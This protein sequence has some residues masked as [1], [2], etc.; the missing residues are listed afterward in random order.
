MRARD[1]ARRLRVTRRSCVV[2]LLIVGSVGCGDDGPEQASR[3]EADNAAAS[4][5]GTPDRF[6]KPSYV[7]AGYKVDV[8]EDRGPRRVILTGKSRSGVVPV[9][10]LQLFTPE[11]G[12]EIRLTPEIRQDG[13]GKFSAKWNMEDRTVLATAAFV[14][15]EEFEKVL[16]SI[17]LTDTTELCTFVREHDGRLVAPSTTPSR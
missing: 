17:A 4:T 8:F 13:A 6:V 16:G 9:V 12:A 1:R 14:P 2:L 5:I 11:P 3:C 15:R 10:D 7:P